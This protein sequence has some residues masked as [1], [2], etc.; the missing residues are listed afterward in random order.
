[1][2]ASEGGR[3]GGGGAPNRGNVEPLNGVRRVHRTQSWSRLASGDARCGGVEDQ[4]VII[5]CWVEFVETARR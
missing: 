3:G 2:E 5:E 4:T 1:M